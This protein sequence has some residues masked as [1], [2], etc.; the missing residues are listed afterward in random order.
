MPI[1]LTLGVG[2]VLEIAGENDHLLT[3]IQAEIQRR[4]GIPPGEEAYDEIAFPIFE[5]LEDH[6]RETF[7][8]VKGADLRSPGMKETIHTWIEER[9]AEI[10]D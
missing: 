5:A 9:L 6:I 4:G 2:H 3:L 8:V 10:E 7:G 1:R